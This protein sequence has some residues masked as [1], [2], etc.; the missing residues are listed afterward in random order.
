MR[1][2]SLLVFL[3]MCVS[4]TAGFQ[5]AVSAKGLAGLPPDVVTAKISDYNDGDKFK[6]SVDGETQE[7]NLL[8]ADAPELD[9]GDLGECFAKDAKDYVANLLKKKQTVYLEKDQDDKDGKERLLRYVWAANSKGDKAYMVNELLIAKGYAQFK[10]N[11]DNTKYASTTSASK[12]RRITRKKQRQGSGA[13]APVHMPKSLQFRRLE[14]ET[15]PLRLALRSKPT[16]EGS[17]S[18]APASMTPTATSR[19]S[20]IEFS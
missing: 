16:V 2:I 20:K 8:G 14:P 15:I 13:R 11:S 18:T 5:Q 19:Q 10:S 17:P 7:V 12:P 3:M 9:E 4:M 1:R 6:V